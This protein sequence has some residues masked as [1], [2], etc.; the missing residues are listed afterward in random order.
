[1]SKT[2]VN[3]FLKMVDGFNGEANNATSA[4]EILKWLTDVDKG[5]GMTEEMAKAYGFDSL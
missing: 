3:N 5:L 1:M 2:D 4:K